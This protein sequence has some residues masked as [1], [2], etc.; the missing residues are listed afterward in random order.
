MCV[1]VCVGEKIESEHKALTGNIAD[2]Y[3]AIEDQLYSHTI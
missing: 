1:C 3:L 2:H